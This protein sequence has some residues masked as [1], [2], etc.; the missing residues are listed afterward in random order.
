[1]GTQSQGPG[2]A[3]QLPNGESDETNSTDFRDPDTGSYMRVDWI[4]PPGEDAVAAWEAQSA[5]FE[6]NHEN[7]VNLGIEGT[8]FNGWEAA[9]WE[10]TYSDG[11][12]DLHAINLGFIVSEEYGFALNF[13]THEE[14]WTASQEIFEAF[15][16]SFEPPR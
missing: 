15:K 11:G 4:S 3:A 8:E 12:A 6:G 16:A 9:E 5:S 7:Y 1:M 14:N 13:Q 2:G 10:Y